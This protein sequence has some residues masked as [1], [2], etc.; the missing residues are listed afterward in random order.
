MPSWDG[1]PFWS[2]LVI[3]FLDASRGPFQTGAMARRERQNGG[4]EAASAPAEL[5]TTA[6]IAR[7]LRLNPKRIYALVQHDRLPAT[8]VSGKWLFPR[9]LVAQWL[10]EHT[11]YPPEGMVQALLDRMVVLQ[12]SDDWLLDQV[13]DELRPRLGHPVLTAAVGSVGGL[14]AVADGLAHLATCHVSDDEVAPFVPPASPWYLVRLCAR[15]QGLLVRRGER[16]RSARR[17]SDLPGK[18][19]RVA[20]RAASTGTHRLARRLLAAE[21]ASAAS[22]C[23]VGPYPSHLDVAMAVRS[24]A[25]DVGLGIKAVAEVAGLDFVPLATEAYELAIPARVLGHPRASSFLASLL[26]GLARAGRRGAPGYSL[27]S[28]GRTRPAPSRTKDPA[29]AP[30]ES[31]P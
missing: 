8:R 3:S 30:V 20:D 24:G 14:R 5:L 6:E 7:W 11:V 22:V 29:A 27:R 10:A 15:E 17:M 2:V 26:D 31:I 13:L 9:A 12:G 16:A 1:Y 18:R 19:L 21:G 4:T 25:A 28:L 23:W